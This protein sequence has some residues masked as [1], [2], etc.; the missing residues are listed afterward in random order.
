MILNNHQV[1][2]MKCASLKIKYKLAY[3]EFKEFVWAT[4]EELKELMN[5]SQD[6][7]FL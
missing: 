7:D 2:L 5:N 1:F 6:L 4:K 3:K